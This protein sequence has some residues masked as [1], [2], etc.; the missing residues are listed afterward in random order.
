[1]ENDCSF[2][3]RFCHALIIDLCTYAVAFV[4]TSKKLLHHRRCS[5]VFFLQLQLTDGNFQGIL[6]LSLNI[7]DLGKI[8]NTY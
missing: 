8:K 6:N 2:A 3:S 4:L 5:R 7:K 1:M